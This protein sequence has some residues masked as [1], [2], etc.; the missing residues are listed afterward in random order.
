MLPANKVGR[1]FNKPELT[2]SK[3]D[4]T[5]ALGYQIFRKIVMICRKYRVKSRVLPGSFHSVQGKVL[6]EMFFTSPLHAMPLSTPG[7]LRADFRISFLDE[8]KD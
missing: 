1:K 3:I 6:H 4:T 7:Y 5:Y 8:R 2:N